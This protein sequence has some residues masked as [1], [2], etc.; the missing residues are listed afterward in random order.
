MDEKEEI[1]MLMTSKVERYT[2][3]ALKH[4]TTRLAKDGQP[5]TYIQDGKNQRAYPLRGK[6]LKAFLRKAAHAN[7]E[8][9]RNDDLNEIIENLY[10]Y[11]ELGEEELIVFLRVGT[12]SEGHVELDS[13]N[14]NGDRI[15]FRNGKVDFKASGSKTLFSRPESMLPLPKAAQEGDWTLLLPFLNMTR[16]D[17]F[18][19]VA[20]MTF[21]MVHPRHTTAYPVLL[22]RGPQGAG[23]SLFCR[24]VIRALVDNNSA[25][26]QLLPSNVK[27]MAISAR[28][29]Y[30]LIYDNVRSL[31]KRQSDDLCVMATG[32]SY[33]SR[34]L[35]TD[36]EEVML[37]VHAPVV[38]NSI[39]NVVE[40]P[41]LAS[42]ILALHLRAMEAGSRREES[43]LTQDLQKKMP[44]IFKG[45]L[46]LCAH[47][48]KAESTAEILFPERLMSFSRWLAALEPPLGLSKGEL[49]KVYSDNLREA[50]LESVRENALAITVLSFAMKRSD[51]RWSGTATSLL[52]ELNKLAPPQTINRSSE[53]PQTPISLSKRLKMVAPALKTQGIDI[54]F[55]HGTQ[56]KVEIS[57]HPPK[58]VKTL[59]GLE[60]PVENLENNVTKLDLAACGPTES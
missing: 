58:T 14:E 31:T 44:V 41:D 20:W 9:L 23:K 1:P 46:D 12:D 37:P 54:D 59:V 2:D 7:G 60:E 3:F 22:V 29:Q 13:G 49:Q 36:Q 38:L 4:L 56:R 15:L 24:G 32:G 51:K 50:S 34:K 26:I 10:A 43:E 55:S 5:Y 52:G 33:G 8:L 27:D 40:E 53:W 19:A 16:E 11:A 48:L 28:S 47:A 45:L 57:Y 42:R 17:Q 30:V 39:H 35:Y 25:G 18:L 6:F 21:V